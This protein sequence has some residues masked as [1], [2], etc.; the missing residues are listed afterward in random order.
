[1]PDNKPKFDPNKKFEP[2]N[3]SGSKPAFDPN[4]KF[5]P[6]D[7]SKKKVSTSEP[8][9][10][11]SQLQEPKSSLEALSTGLENSQ[12]AK[13]TNVDLNFGQ[14]STETISPITAPLK[15]TKEQ[16]LPITPEKPKGFE[17]I[18]EGLTKSVV[19]EGLPSSEILDKTG[20]PIIDKQS[21][22]TPLALTPEQL[23]QQKLDIKENA[24][25]KIFQ[26]NLKYITPDK[27]DFRE[28]KLVPY[29]QDKFG[30][31]GF[32]FE[33]TGM[34][35]EMVVSYIPDGQQEIR[36]I[37]I[38]LQPFSDEEKTLEHQ[39]LLNFMQNTRM[40]DTEKQFVGGE[41]LKRENFATQE[42]FEKAGE[43]YQNKLVQLMASDPYKYGD[44]LIDEDYFNNIVN[45]RTM[46]LKLAAKNFN[47]IRDNLDEA[48]RIYESNPTPE[49]LIAYNKQFSEAKKLQDNLKE[50]YND[51][52]EIQ[53]N[54]QKAVGISVARKEKEN[55]GSFI[56]M[57]GSGLGKGF[58]SIEKMIT[59]AAIDALPAVL[60]TEGTIDPIT[61]SKLTE[62]GYTDAEMKDYASKEMKRF[63][64][65][66]LEEGIQNI[67]SGGTTTKEY[68]QSEDRNTFEK[69]VN[70]LSESVGAAAAGGG[71]PALTKLSFFAMS[72][73]AIDEEMS[74]KEFDGL[75][76]NE[77][78]LV[79]VPY[80]LTIGA[81]ENLG[82]KFSTSTS[83]SP[84]LNNIT[85]S[86][87]A[88]TFTT[89]PKNA[90]IDV[91]QDAIEKNT[92]AFLVEKGLKIVGGALVEGATE[93]LQQI[94]EVAIKNIANAV[95][96][97][98]YF[99]NVPDITT[100]EGIKETLALALEDAKYG[101]Y[102][103]L[104]M[105]GGETALSSINKKFNDKK[106]DD[107]FS[108]FMDNMTDEKLLNVTINEINRKAE[109]G[110]ISNQEAVDQLK[111]VETAKATV[112]SI[113]EDLSI[114]DKR[115][116]YDLINE[117]TKL[118]NEIEGKD[119]NLVAAQTEKINQI[120]ERLKVIGGGEIKVEEKTKTTE[121]PKAPAEK[122]TE[123]KTTVTE[124]SSETKIDV[125][126]TNVGDIK[127]PE[128]QT[129]EGKE[130]A[131]VDK[132]GKFFSEKEVLKMDS[133]QLSEMNIQNP[134]EKVSTH[135]ETIFPVKKEET[136]TIK[137]SVSAKNA[138]TENEPSGK[139]EQLPIETQQN[140]ETIVRENKIVEPMEYET[141]QAEPVGGGENLSFVKIGNS[142][143]DPEINNNEALSGI[144]VS[145]LSEPKKIQSRIN[146]LSSDLELEK[147]D[148]MDTSKL[149]EAISFLESYLP[150]NEKIEE[151]PK[152]EI[153][154][155]EVP[156]TPPI[157][158]SEQE[159][160]PGEPEKERSFGKQ[161]SE[162]EISDE[163]KEGLSKEGKFY[164]PISNRITAKEA[165]AVIKEKGVDG[166]I[167]AV[168]DFR[169]RLAPR[170]RVTMAIQLI[171]ML[172]KEGTPESYDKAARVANEISI[173]ATELGQ[174][175]QVFS[176]WNK[177]GFDGVIR[178]Y[179]KNQEEATKKLKE[180]HKGIYQG[181]KEGYKSGTKSA[182]KKAT[183][184]VFTKSKSKASKIRAFGL[185]KN[186][187]E[188]R[189]KEAL[190]KLKKATTKGGGTL[191][192]GGLN[193][194]AIEAIVEYG[195]MVFA[196]GVRNFKEWSAKIKEISND[197]SEE[198]LK[199]I[200][201]NDESFGG[202]TFNELSKISEIEEIVADH[203]SKSTDIDSLSKTL[204][205]AFG[206]DKELADGLSSEITE[207]FNKIVQKERVKEIAKK[208]PLTK[209]VRETIEKIASED[210]L[211]NQE[212]EDMISETFGIKK[213]TSE[214]IEKIKEL[215]KERD[216][217]P[218]GFLK[219]DATRETLSYMAKLNGISKKDIFWSMYY[220]SIL[221]GHETQILNIA[222]NALNISM[223]TLV[224]AI[225]KTVISRDPKAVGD[226]VSGMIKG[227]KEGSR[228][229]GQVLS[230]GQSARK[231]EQKLEAKDTLENIDFKG[232]KLNPANY[233]KYVGRF[234]FAIDS[235]AYLTANGS[236]TQEL[237]REVAKNEGLSGKAL[238]ERVSEILNQSQEVYSEALEQATKEVT[239]INDSAENKMSGRRLNRT[240]KIRT[241]E[242][243][244][245]K[246]PDEIKD[247][248]HDFSSFVTYNYTPK[249]VLGKFSLALSQL[250]NEVQLFKLIV[251]FTRVVANVLNQQLDYTPYGYLR[252]LKWNVGARMDKRT[253]A[254]NEKERNRLLIKAT[255]GTTIM[256]SL[257]ALSK[258]YEDDEDPW[259]EITG[260]GPSDMNKKNQL[261]SQGWRPYSIKIGDTRIS[262]QYTPFGVALSFVGNWLDNEKYK[263]LDQKDLLTK[264]T[265]ALTNSAGSILDMSFLTGLSGFFE[266][267]GKDVDPAKSSENF[268]KTLG[269][270]GTTFIPNLFKQIDKAYD[271]T[272][273]DSQTLGASILKEIPIVKEL[274]DLKPK[275]NAFGQPV[276]KE[277]NRF[278]QGVTKDP[279][280]K[281]MAENRLFAPG[282]SPDA[283]NVKGE[284]MGDNEFYDYAKLSGNLTYDYIK[285]NLPEIKSNFKSME[286]GEKQKYIKGLFN[287][288]RKQAKYQISEK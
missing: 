151:K 100:T 213:L 260:K 238:R 268:Q 49:G 171:E 57:I 196:D 37:S 77:K 34:G 8:F 16:T 60:G 237:A 28:E 17:F 58:T 211:S 89:L 173:Y 187:I 24:S 139:T 43:K 95:T 281:F 117:R 254:N 174:G 210:N 96:E 92:A 4:K 156:P 163:I 2:V 239:A 80:G 126:D 140:N 233:Y 132:E 244:A 15:A 277:G 274:S 252:A 208:V 183:Q 40:T 195:A 134:S 161:V 104:I 170:T 206:L 124:K 280:W 164:I 9:T 229:F 209:R 123:T 249:G 149:E 1:M 193:K 227:F 155:N 221:S 203:F 46:N 200:W 282:L 201:M 146:D 11:A 169:N 50:R 81:L 150:T 135:L 231:L 108:V 147:S 38:N 198:E 106:S 130:S 98:D 269:K 154:S 276:S 236:K 3:N 97:K 69:V 21:K 47:V 175:I 182:G 262:Y 191:T 285:E 176:L 79:S 30:K 109:S 241:S 278:Y 250:G 159:T 22:V 258:M 90:S 7:G 73:N 223:E 105:S 29:L 216:S 167:L 190:E 199:S 188:K 61:R 68:S 145:E 283:K 111:A 141:I 14:P 115:K 133:K 275:L 36:S 242:I 138:P 76:E 19:G 202:K 184:N 66:K 186:E 215:T 10:R 12:A 226:I 189:K 128:I 230:T 220:A 192:S 44:K 271:P 168:L 27:I 152:Q 212:I 32:S 54:Y 246:I 101:F 144:P 116:S 88:R 137:E 110:E 131:Y 121:I 107:E 224:S 157:T 112:Q 279:I 129:V 93:G 67:A 143:I 41:N 53:K 207:E 55:Q 153:E 166:S 75:T 114:S 172:N 284:E 83:K 94:D 13:G 218:E 71:N 235:A 39:K 127:K 5:E 217:R 74:G 204:Q 179:E 232:G 20:V 70:M 245:E 59:G 265:F 243:V 273:Y 253:S 228:E 205:D 255:L 234:M 142:Y 165:N 45:D 82:F 52:N 48:K 99:Q 51:L 148:N 158:L 120:N 247:E 18:Q 23:A 194:D 119:K 180:K 286:Q 103:G 256:V 78:L 270:I 84:L 219:D 264:S 113:P 26:N 85:K 266:S 267:L 214:Q 222:S 25:T 87:L 56:G 248:A 125:P 197:I 251:P 63:F 118:E 261:Y 272:I 257:Y 42:E 263:E 160:E 185:D 102:G 259:F 62:L 6:V 65:P 181:T 72:K 64:M 122:P 287:T 177:L 86:I 31:E 35:D 162:S 225:E 33:E 288:F 91:I 136:P 240:I 178:A